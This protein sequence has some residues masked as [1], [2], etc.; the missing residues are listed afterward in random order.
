MPFY[1]LSWI[2]FYSTAQ[3]RQEVNVNNIVDQ[4]EVKDSRDT[5]SR[6][7]VADSGVSGMGYQDSVLAGTGQLDHREVGD[8]P[9]RKNIIKRSA[10]LKSKVRY[11]CC[12][13]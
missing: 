1:F 6:G 5:G 12:V 10:S 13:S 11:R 4:F 3:I 8:Q 7:S 9:K 2:P